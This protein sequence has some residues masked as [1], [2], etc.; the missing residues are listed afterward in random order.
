MATRKD[1][2]K[3]KCAECKQE[4]SIKECLPNLICYGTFTYHKDCFVSM[5]ER[6]SGRKGSK[7]CWAECLQKIPELQ[8]ETV[9][10]LNEIKIK[11]DVYSFML[12]Q[13]DLVAIP[14]YVFEKLD[15]I[16]SGTYYGLSI[17]IPPADLLDMWQRKM[18]E[19]NKIYN[20][21]KSVGKEMDG[22]GRIN[23]DLAILINKYDSYLKWKEKMRILETESIESQKQML[24]AVNFQNLSKHAKVI[25]QEKEDDMDDLLDELFG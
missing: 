7:P 6:K 19:L 3:R 17:P 15:S 9:M 1:M 21:N 2:D 5:C 20:K 11:D 13:Y 4:I 10:R 23:Y 18:G 14:K 22:V 12:E 16:Y 24:Q 8:H 25:E